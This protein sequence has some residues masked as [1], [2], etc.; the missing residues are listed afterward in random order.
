MQLDTGHGGVGGGHGKNTTEKKKT[1]RTKR[2]SGSFTRWG[3]QKMSS[4]RGFAYNSYFDIYRVK[5]ITS[6]PFI[7]SGVPK[8]LTLHNWK[9]PPPRSI[10]KGGPTSVVEL[11]PFQNGH[12]NPLSENQHSRHSNE[13]SPFNSI[14]SAPKIYR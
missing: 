1:K 2:E 12:P 4:N 9:G 13:R 11:D 10:Y 7:V 8:G 5:Y 3:P 14:P 6:E